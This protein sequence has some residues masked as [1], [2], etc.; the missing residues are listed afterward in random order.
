MHRLPFRLNRLH[1]A[2]V[3]LTTLV[4]AL[5]GGGWMLVHERDEE[6]W[7]ACIPWLIK[8]H[9]GAAMLML[10][11]LGGLA[12]HVQRAWKAR[13]NRRSGVVLIGVN[14]FLILT[15]YGLY[16]AGSEEMRAWFSRWHAWVGLGSALLLPLHVIIGR[17]VVRKRMQK[18]SSE[19]H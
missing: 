19:P 1:K 2:V 7:R 14:L 11:L 15:G 16:Y 10:L 5:T 6:A 3:Y 4:L 18:A 12:I 8:T 9:G 13:L 17:I